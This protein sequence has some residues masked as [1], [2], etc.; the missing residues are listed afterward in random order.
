MAATREDLNQ[1]LETPQCE[2]LN[3]SKEHTL[4]HAI[5]LE[6]RGDPSSFI[7][8]DCDEELMMCACCAPSASATTLA[9]PRRAKRLP[10]AAPVRA[11]A[12]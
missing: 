11:A 9:P 8:S 7:Q 6:S 12:T 3:A 4:R 5:D 1:C 10:F 2:C